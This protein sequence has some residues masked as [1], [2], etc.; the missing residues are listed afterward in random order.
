MYR[1]LLGPFTLV[2]LLVLA[3][4][5]AEFAAP[6]SKLG[7]SPVALG[8]TVQDLLDRS[9][10]RFDKKDYRAANRL[11]E[12]G[13]RILRTV[14]SERRELVKEIDAVLEKAAEETKGSV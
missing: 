9:A 14:L 10:E 1:P 8:E 2:L 7:V 5:P 4:P 13:L 11:L 3:C 6:P 12:G